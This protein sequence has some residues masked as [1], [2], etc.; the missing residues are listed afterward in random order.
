MYIK[1]YQKVFF[2]IAHNKH[3]NN[4]LF[5]KAAYVTVRQLTDIQLLP[6]S[7]QSPE[8]KLGLMTSTWLHLII[9]K[10]FIILHHPYCCFVYTLYNLFAHPCL[11]Y[12]CLLILQYTVLNILFL[13]FSYLYL[14]RFSCVTYNCTVHGADLTYIS[15]L[16][17]FCIIVYVKKKKIFNLL[18]RNIHLRPWL[19]WGH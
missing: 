2:D 15:P 1:V 18:R 14:C 11:Y 13:F 17:I 3:V 9:S 8:L 16:V 4:I 5:R 19:Y 7:H 12:H 10:I 6:P